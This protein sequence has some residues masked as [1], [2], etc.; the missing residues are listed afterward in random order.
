MIHEEPE[1]SKTKWIAVLWAI[2]MW[3]GVL[4]ILKIVDALT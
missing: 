4:A 3:A 2:V 1:S